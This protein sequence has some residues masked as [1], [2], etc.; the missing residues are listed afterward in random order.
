MKRSW[1]PTYPCRRR[2]G[3]TGSSGSSHHE[4][5]SHDMRDDLTAHSAPYTFT[6]AIHIDRRAQSRRAGRWRF[7]MAVQV[8]RRLTS[9]LVLSV[10][11][12]APLLR[13]INIINR[14]A[15]LTYHANR[16]PP[17]APSSGPWEGL[18][19]QRR[20]S[21]GHR[22]FRGEWEQ[23]QR[24]RSESYDGLFTCH[25]LL[26]GSDEHRRLQPHHPGVRRV[27]QP[28]W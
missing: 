14:S 18:A 28:V 15:S 4:R 9:L 3:S 23:R 10:L 22:L 19:G 5:S 21:L 1:G 6:H 12:R 26:Q 20:H 17:L 27:H 11:V 16:Y 8:L 2:I 13:S 25:R 7:T 24:H